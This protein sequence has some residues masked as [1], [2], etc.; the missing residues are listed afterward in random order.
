MPISH[1]CSSERTCTKGSGAVVF[2]QLKKKEGSVHK[3]HTEGQ[4]HK[5]SHSP[6]S[7]RDITFQKKKKS[8]KIT[9]LENRNTKTR[10]T[11]GS[12]TFNPSAFL[13]AP[14]PE[15]DKHL[16]PVK[17]GPQHRQKKKMCN[18]SRCF[19]KATERYQTLANVLWRP[20]LAAGM[21]GGAGG[22]N[23]KCV[24]RSTPTHVEI[25]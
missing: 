4:T 12:Y 16:L 22:R 15:Q 23:G 5:P 24:A 2:E 11:G 25:K 3:R 1:L 21:V 6:V 13:S 9:N 19:C 8:S 20:A 7:R 10:D 18:K 14:T 17:A